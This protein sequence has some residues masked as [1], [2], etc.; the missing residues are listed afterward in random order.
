MLYRVFDLKV[1]HPAPGWLL[2]DDKTYTHEFLTQNEVILEKGKLRRASI[3]ELEG[4]GLADL[5]PT[6]TTKR[7]GE[8]PAPCDIR[9]LGFPQS[10]AFPAG[11]PAYDRCTEY[12]KLTRDSLRTA[13][14][15]ALCFVDVLCRRRAQPPLHIFLQML[16][17]YKRWR[18]E[19]VLAEWVT[20]KYTRRYHECGRYLVGWVG[21]V[22]MYGAAEQDLLE[23]LTDSDGNVGDTF[24]HL[25]DNLPE[26]M[27][28]L[29]LV[30]D[31]CVA[32]ALP[33]PHSS[34]LHWPANSTVK[35]AAA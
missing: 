8:M 23:L 17:F 9:K 34:I 24:T 29:N 10:E 25:A 19:K 3:D 6:F 35:R 4:N 20:K 12:R 11:T 2:N 22:L 1:T 33:L 28:Y 16:C 31:C 18:G 15:V 13:R 21:D 32:F 27:Q 30:R 7:G 5:M 26:C 14:K